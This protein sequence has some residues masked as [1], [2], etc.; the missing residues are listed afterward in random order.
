MESDRRMDDDDDDDDVDD[1]FRM[2]WRIFFSFV[3]T[4]LV[5]FVRF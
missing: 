1:D 2:V 5:I 3:L 4:F